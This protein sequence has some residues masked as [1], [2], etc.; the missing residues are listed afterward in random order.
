MGL[1][2][3][4]D[5]WTVV[6]KKK[7]RP[8]RAS[9]SFDAVSQGQPIGDVD[10]EVHKLQ[11]Q[12]QQAVKNIQTSGF[13]RALQRC[14]QQSEEDF[15]NHVDDLPDYKR[16]DIKPWA[17]DHVTRLVVYGLGSLQEGSPASTYQLALLPLLK[18]TLPN[19][20][21]SPSFYD[22]AFGLVDK[23]L[24]TKL[25]YQVMS[26]E[27]GEASQVARQP[28]LFYMPH[29][30]RELTESL[31]QANWETGTLPNIAILGNS[32]HEYVLHLTSSKAAASRACHAYARKAVLE[33]PVSDRD[34]PLARA[35]NNL[36]L[37]L[38]PRPD[39]TSFDTLPPLAPQWGDSIP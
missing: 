14:F 37:Q 19:L 3:V 7:G 13:S 16:Q 9:N 28:T 23:S 36:A 10:S 4:R 2:T 26:R 15:S 27:E 17:W 30:E 24:L 33:V 1:F 22:P 35:F 38:F 11:L 32:F 21:D 29:C 5:I 25:G 18:A 39:L 6:T 34:S 12:V 20:R 8:A 31:L